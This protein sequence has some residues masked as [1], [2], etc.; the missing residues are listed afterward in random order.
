M[1][2]D[3]KMS[4]EDMT[5]Y[6][7]IVPERKAS[8]AEFPD[9]MNDEIKEYLRKQGINALY[10]HQTEMF[11]KAGRGENTV[12]TT[13]TASGKTGISS[14]CPAEDIGRSTHKGDFRL[15]DESAGE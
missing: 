3:E 14:S 13:S 5:A 7:R 12:I 4:I 11:E 2:K 6:M 8:Y 1:K 9:T 15:S 10:T